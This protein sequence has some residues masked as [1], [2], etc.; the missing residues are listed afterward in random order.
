MRR[1]RWR[2]GEYGTEVEDRGRCR[3]EGGRKGDVRFV[4]CTGMGTRHGTSM[5]CA[6]TRQSSKH[7][8]GTMLGIHHATL[9]RCAGQG[10]APCDAQG[11][12]FAGNLRAMCKSEG[13]SSKP[14]VLR[15]DKNHVMQFRAMRRCDGPSSN[16]VR[17]VGAEAPY[18]STTR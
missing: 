10:A 6:M 12:R 13:P 16:F 2:V 3:V 4:R 1:G 7:R 15:K 5:R 14:Q 9:M 11:R 18:L 17:C 8:A